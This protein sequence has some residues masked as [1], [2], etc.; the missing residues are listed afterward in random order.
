MVVWKKKIK[1][2]SYKTINIFTA[3]YA[4]LKGV[5]WR[6]HLLYFIY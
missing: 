6:R 2:G 1:Y 5:S 3:L 4:T